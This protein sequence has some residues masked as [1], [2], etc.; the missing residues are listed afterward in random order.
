MSDEH[1]PAETRIPRYG[2]LAASLLTLELLAGIQTYL[3]VTVVPLVAAD[4]HAHQFYGVITGAAQVAT[5]VTMPLGPWLLRRVRV[6][7]LLVFL[8]WVAV[9][10]GVV[11]ALAPGIAVFLVG[12][13]ISGLAAGALATV[14]LAAIVSVLPASWRRLVLAGYNLM[15]VATSLVGPLYAG[16]V[17]STLGWRWALVLYLPLLLVARVVVARELRDTMADGGD[18][19]LALAWAVALAAGV[20]LLSLVGLRAVSAGGALAVGA[21]GAVVAV[22]AAAHLLPPGVFRVRRGRASAVATMGL[23]TGAF[24]GADAIVAIV[25]H[26]VLGGGPRAIAVVLGVSG[27]AWALLGLYAARHPASEPGA[28]VSRSSLGAGLMTLGLVVMA[29]GASSGRV[30]AVG[31]GW[32]VA[33]VGMGL[34]YL[35]T[36]N[37][38]VEVPEEADGVPPA[39]AAA[40]VVLVEAVAAAVTSTVAAAVL[41]RAVDGAGP[42]PAA[43]GVLL[44]CALIAAGVALTARRAVARDQV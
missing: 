4:L 21:I 15:W 26:D 22:V 9:A 14:S 28:Y 31:L 35:D 12:R 10:G 42:E 30:P 5:F 34:V 38:V 3:L 43:V 13:V 23:V 37:H 29:L 41:G 24:F 16:W 6:D 18:E 17:A 44:G 7:R 8:T 1:A 32:A 36:L 33:G 25:V 2:I 11:S 39:R 40:A 19:R 27:L 20:A